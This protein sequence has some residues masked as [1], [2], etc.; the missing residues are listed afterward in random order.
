MPSIHNL[1]R[2]TSTSVDPESDRWPAALAETLA[3]VDPR[4][5]YIGAD[6]V[7]TGTASSLTEAI[8]SARPYAMTVADDVIALDLDTDADVI[9]ADDLADR[10]IAEGWPVLRTASGR[11]GHRHLWAVIPSPADRADVVDDIEARGLPRPRPVMR[12]PLSPHRLDLPVTA[13]DDVDIFLDAV[14]AARSVVRPRDTWR[15][16]LRTGHHRGRDKSGSATV[17]RICIGAARDGLTVDDVRPLL[18]DRRNRGGHGY[19]RR[20]ADRGIDA[21]DRWLDRHVWPSAAKR[22]ASPPPADAADARG[23][24]QDVANRVDRHHW[25]GV[26]GATDRAVLTAIIARGMTRGSITPSMSYREI[27]EAAPCGL[28]TVQRATTRLIASGWLQVAR[29]GRG[30]TETAN[31]GARIEVA[32]AT[33]WRITTPQDARDDHTGRTPPAVLA[34]CGHHAR[35]DALADICRWGGLGLNARR[36]LDVLTTGPMTT[37]E[38]ADE[39]NLN[40]GNLR[41]RLLPRIASHGLIVSV[42]DRWCIADDLDDRAVA[43]AEALDLDGRTGEIAAR[44]QAERDAYLDHRERTRDRRDAQRRTKIADGLGRRRA[45]TFATFATHDEPDRIADELR[46]DLDDCNDLTN[47]TTTTVDQPR[48]LIVA[49]N[50]GDDANVTADRPAGTNVI[51]R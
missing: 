35:A 22:A 46:L 5:F 19:R 4:P 29:W 13:V 9:A 15:D 39:L 33:T 28:R 25:A 44:H 11:A 36:V 7:R 2:V 47:I 38:I 24:L 43:A 37:R 45:E 30:A 18:A 23:R 31:D 27:A 41:A 20:I 32:R 51:A 34:Q 16:I 14:L 6:N 21:A 17:W 8:A 12:P 48:P 10:L 50:D 1:T 3:A 42:G 26:A 40:V 49:L